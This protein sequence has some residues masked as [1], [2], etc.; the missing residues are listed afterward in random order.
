MSAAASVLLLATALYWI[1]QVQI[2]E[3][4]SE[5]VNQEWIDFENDSGITKKHQA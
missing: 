1:Y 5:L 2:K 3:N 4:Q